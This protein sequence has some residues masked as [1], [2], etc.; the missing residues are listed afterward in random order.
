MRP[1]ISNY[2]SMCKFF[3]VLIFCGL[4]LLQLSTNSSADGSVWLGI[5]G[6]N[7]DIFSDY[8][9]KINFD[10]TINLTQTSELNN[11]DV[12]WD[13]F[14]NNLITKVGY[15]GF[16]PGGVTI[17]NQDN[18]R[19]LGDLGFFNE[20]GMEFEI[21]SAFSIEN[22]RYVYV[23]FNKKNCA[24]AG[25]Y[26]LDTKKE[27]LSFDCIE[28]REDFQLNGVGGAY[29]KT[30]DGRHLFTTGTPTSSNSEI[31]ILAQN[32]TSPWGKILELKETKTGKLTFSIYSFGHRNPQGIF[33]YD[34]AIYAVEHGPMGGDEL[35][36]IKRGK[37]YGW[38]LQSLGSHYDLTPISKS[39]VIGKNK[40]IP[41]MHA[42]L[43]SIG[44]SYVESC[45][46]SYAEYYAPLRC[47]AVSGMVGVAIYLVVFEENGNVLFTEKIK[48]GARIRKF[49]FYG[50]DLVAVTDFEGLILG[51]VTQ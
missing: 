13:F 46:K 4:L 8:G 47:L 36:H 33:E 3:S 14:R 31:R 38:P 40:T 35:N 41:S 34:N 19:V 5:D 29:L 39:Y 32:L 37:N 12:H 50:D 48:L 43:P 20:D 17:I 25:I 28:Q 16:N 10:E 26:N 18:E 45:P 23:A 2:T 22:N 42:F 15:T 44:I 27:A 21:K 7:E 9:D 11:F 24:S 30:F 51:K 49:K 6:D 1:V